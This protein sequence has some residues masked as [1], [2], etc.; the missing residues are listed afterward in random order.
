MP[1]STGAGAGAG[2]P[3]GK[4]EAL[5]FEIPAIWQSLVAR[6]WLGPPWYFG[7]F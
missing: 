5:A 2:V 3:A 6:M 4:N 7:R 1:N